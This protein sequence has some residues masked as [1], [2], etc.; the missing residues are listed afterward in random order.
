[1]PL[2]KIKKL[3]SYIFLSLILIVNQAFACTGIRITTQDGSVIY[4]RTLEF[5]IDLNSHL[6]FVPRNIKYTGTTETNRQ[7]GKQWQTKYAFTGIAAYDYPQIID[8]I[9]E[10]GLA[11]GLFYFPDYASYPALTEK[12]KSH[13]LAPW[14][15]GTYLLSNFQNIDEVKKGLEAVT[16][17]PVVLKEYN[18]SPPVH[19]VVHDAQGKSLVIEYV[20]GQL[21]T[22]DNP[23]GV[24]TNSPSFD[25]HLTNLSNYVNLTLTNVPAFKL[26]GTKFVGFGQGSGLHGLPGDFTPPSRFIRAV[27]F[28][29]AALPVETGKEGVLAVFHLLNQFD[30]PKGS[31]KELDK[32]Q[33]LFDHT[34]WTSVSN[35]KDKIFYFKTYKNQQIKKI[36]LMKMN[37]DDKKISTF[38]MLGEE[39]IQDVVK[40]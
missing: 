8:G 36:E 19:Y 4:G 23:L 18:F 35:L 21:K 9:N 11:V 31:I 20:K 1:M 3:P 25:W 13:A 15:L 39:V 27:V 30:I 28:S 2:L 33:T 26:A 7:N 38:P 40:K 24:I 6:I 17:V 37:V 14:E 34:L 10:K 22:Y 16:I 12:N 29:Q 5:P 32:D